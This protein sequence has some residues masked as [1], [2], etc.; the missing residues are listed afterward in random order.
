MHTH[1]HTPTLALAPTDNKYAPGSSTD[2]NTRTVCQF[3]PHALT[4]DYQRRCIQS[5]HAAF[6][7]NLKASLRMEGILVICSCIINDHNY[8][9]DLRIHPV[10]MDALRKASISLKSLQER[11]GNKALNVTR[12]TAPGLLQGPR[13]IYCLPDWWLRVTQLLAPATLARCE[14]DYSF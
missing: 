7:K 13:L 11:I 5:N 4:K 14:R 12:S 2:R 8:V 9:L 3:L 1:T 10:F 6:S